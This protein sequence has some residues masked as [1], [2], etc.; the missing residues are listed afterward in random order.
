M[1]DQ[2]SRLVLRVGLNLPIRKTFD[3]CLTEGWS[4]PV[5][6]PGVRL[7]VPF[8]GKELIGIL[9]EVHTNQP[10]YDL[11]PILLQIDDE[12]VLDDHILQLLNWSANYYCHP[13]GEVIST[14]LPAHL[15]QG[16]QPLPRLAHRWAL[17]PAAQQT[18]P[19]LPKAP[20]QQAI[21]NFLSDRPQGASDTELNAQFTNWRSPMRS[22]VVKQHVMAQTSP[23]TSTAAVISYEEGHQLNAAQQAAFDRI[24]SQLNRYACFL[25]YG[26][27]GSGKTEV[28]LQLVRRTL[29]LG[30][31]ALILVPEIGLTPQLA[32]R[33]RRVFLPVSLSC[34][35]A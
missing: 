32:S 31:Q 29:M 2:S 27:T 11:K 26:V 30:K 10:S 23:V 19:R 22:L 12:P 16:R 21:L 35:P 5:P 18:V 34:I 4:K 6:Q 9:L 24:N 17:G 14:A 7:K 1:P 20:K 25:L 13:V 33:F 8:A 3:Y 15:K 28:Y